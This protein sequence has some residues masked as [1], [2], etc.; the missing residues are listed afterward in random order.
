MPHARNHLC[1]RGLAVFVAE[2]R[3]HRPLPVTVV[4]RKAWRDVVG[5]QYRF[6]CA[7][8]GKLDHLHI[9]LAADALF[10]RL[11]LRQGRNGAFAAVAVGRKD[12]F[13]NVVIDR[14]D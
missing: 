9:R 1:Q 13:P 3:V 12:D 10:F 7:R 11:P 2:Q 8:V 5:Y 6:A 4:V 14:Q